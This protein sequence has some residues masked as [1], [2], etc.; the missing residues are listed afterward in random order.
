MRNANTYIVN[1]ARMANM[2]EKSLSSYDARG[3]I[4]DRDWLI[5]FITTECQEVMDQKSA[6]SCADE[7]ITALY[8]ASEIMQSVKL[9]EETG[10]EI[11]DWLLF[12]IMELKQTIPPIEYRAFLLTL[13]YEMNKAAEEGRH[14]I[15]DSDD[16][17]PFAPYNPMQS[18]HDRS[19]ITGGAFGIMAGISGSELSEVGALDAPISN[20]DVSSGL[21]N[22]LLSEY[23]SMTEMREFT[24]ID[25]DI[26]ETNEIAEQI[27]ANAAHMGAASMTIA[28]GIYAFQHYRSMKQ[29]HTKTQAMWGAS[30]NSGKATGIK[31]AISGALTVGAAKGAI[32][33]ISGGISTNTV[34]AMAIVG[35]EAGKAMH[36]CI[37][38]N[39]SVIE[40]ADRMG[41]YS[42]AGICA[43]GLSL[44]GSSAVTAFIPTVGFVGG[45]TLAAGLAGN[46]IGAKSGVIVYDKTK[47][48]VQSVRKMIAAES[49]KVKITTKNKSF[50]R[51][52]LPQ[53][54]HAEVA[55]GR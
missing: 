4:S 46:V 1:Y 6:T 39:I 19:N 31:A 34:S 20:D 25:V 7:T 55:W 8:S 54:L 32:P 5:Q 35:L 17:D 45:I 53:L 27:I 51:N 49:H 9:A 24:E 10:T 42:T 23:K 37:Q 48:I 44:A 16:N 38:G 36:D 50:S 14:Y 22:S 3:T 33:F 15:A 28:A 2:I 41:R 12:R 40:A 11:R 52:L 18:P 13:L 30:W 29:G 47:L 21:N 26:Y 43:L